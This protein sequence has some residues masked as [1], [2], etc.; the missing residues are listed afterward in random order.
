MEKDL[1]KCV[2]CGREGLDDVH[3]HHIV[4][5]CKDGKITEPTCY[6]CESFIHGTWSHNE[7]RDIYNTVDKVKA[8][9]LY[10]KFLKWLL[11]QP[12]DKKHRTL[13]NNNKP[14]GKYK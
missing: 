2:F 10:Q 7:L 11:K 5:R 9:E 14:K 6:D 1:T 4:P 12:I 8:T 3:L 13:R